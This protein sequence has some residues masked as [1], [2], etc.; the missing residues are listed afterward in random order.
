MRLALIPLLLGLSGCVTYPDITQSRS[1]CRMD[2]G[3]WC[4]FVREAAV[5][6]YPY[7]LASTNAYSDDSDIY[8]DLGRSLERIA[9]LEIDPRDRRKGF[10]Y[11][12]FEQ[13]EL[14]DQSGTRGEL[15]ARILAFRG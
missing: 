14:I 1:P 9:R 8:V 10:D 5:E 3:G 6:S 13:Y 11:E 12:L 2:P 7:A 4:A 15:K